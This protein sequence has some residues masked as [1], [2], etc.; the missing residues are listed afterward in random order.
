MDLRPGAWQSDESGRAER[1]AATFPGLGGKLAGQFEKIAANP[2][3]R[4]QRTGAF[5][6]HSGAPPLAL[7][8]MA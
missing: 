8:T 1:Y 2:T 4:K 5:E 7:F 3:T 6:I